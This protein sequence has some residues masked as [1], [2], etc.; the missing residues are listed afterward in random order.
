MRR[1]ALLTA[2]A[3]IWS[4][5][6]AAA[7]TYPNK[8]IKMVV[9]VAAGG[10]IDTIARLFAEQMQPHLGQPIVVENRPGAGGT[11]GA[12]SAAT[13]DPDGYTLLFSTLQTFAIAPAL[14]QNPG[15]DPARLVPIALTAEF[16]FVFVV[17]AQIPANTVKEFVAFAKNSKEKLAFGG[18]LATPAH[19]FGELFKRVNDLDMV[20]VPYRG[21]APS[22]SDLISARTHMAFDAVTTLIPL[23]REGKLRPLAVMSASRSPL[24]PDAPTIAESGYADFPGNP[25]TAIVAPPGTPEPIVRRVND[26]INAALKAPETREKMDKLGL[27]PL[28]GTPR[29]LADM[30][31]ADAPKW[32]E[33]VRASGAKAE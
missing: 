5:A 29:D 17:P 12:R 11:V 30:I 19:L 13:A 15:Y 28:G 4:V 33:I 16:P 25:W 7:Q 3:V 2:L 23:I 18:S 1:T 32:R 31:A 21:L 10:P 14:Y 24:F 20:Y 9:T 8:P 27:S 22:I 6:P 26:A